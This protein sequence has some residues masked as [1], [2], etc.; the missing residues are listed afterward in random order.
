MFNFEGLKIFFYAIPI[1]MRNAIDGL[2]VKVAQNMSCDVQSGVF[3]FYNKGRNKLKILYW[4]RNGFWMIYK[5]LEKEKFKIPELNG[6][7]VELT[8]QQLRW[9]LDG[10]DYTKLEGHKDLKYRIYS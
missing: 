7:E 4:E 8:T 6:K 2:S 10:L 9:I 5:R 3:V 1:D